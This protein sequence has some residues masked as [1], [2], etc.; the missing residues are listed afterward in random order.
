MPV[1][2]FGIGVVD[3]PVPAMIFAEQPRCMAAALGQRPSPVRAD[4]MEG[5]DLVGCRADC[6]DRLID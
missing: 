4:I 1:D 2:Y 3:L 6:D 5:V